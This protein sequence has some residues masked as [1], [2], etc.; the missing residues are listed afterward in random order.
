MAAAM[1][2]LSWRRSSGVK[3]GSPPVGLG[4]RPRCMRRL[5]ARVAGVS[6]GDQLLRPSP[7]G[8]ALMSRWALAGSLVKTTS[9]R[10][11]SPLSRRGAELNAASAACSVLAIR[12][13]MSFGEMFE[14][15]ETLT[16]TVTTDT[17]SPEGSRNRRTS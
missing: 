4:I 9:T 6:A 14:L 2:L 17:Y 13:R 10:T 7:R 12:R 15:G 5:S 3:P 1:S 11:R 16:R 8:V